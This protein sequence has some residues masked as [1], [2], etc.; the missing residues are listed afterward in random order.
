MA[1]VN[2]I[3]YSP[4]LLTYQDQSMYLYTSAQGCTLYEENSLTP[5]YQVHEP[6]LLA[7]GVMTAPDTVHLV[8]LKATGDLTYILI[9]SSGIPQIVS[10]G[11]LDIHSI[12]YSK[13]LLFPTNKSIHIFYAYSHQAIPNLWHI[14]HRYWNGKSWISVH[15]GEV[16]HSKEP[17]F[18]VSLD[19]NGNIHLL[20]MTFQGRQSIVFSNL[21][22]ITFNIWGGL[23]EALR[24]QGEAI[25]MNALMTPDNT[26]HLFWIIR[27]QS[28]QYELRWAQRIHAQDLASSWSLAPAPLRSFNAPWK[29]L[30]VM[31]KNGT[32]WIIADASET[33]LMAY[34]G[35]NWKPVTSSPANHRPLLWVRREE[36]GLYITPWLEDTPNKRSPIFHQ[37]LG[38]I[39]KPPVQPESPN[40]PAD[41]APVP[42]VPAYNPMIASVQTMPVISPAIITAPLTSNENHDPR[43][44]SIEPLLESVAHLQQENTNLTLALQEVQ[45]K[46]DQVLCMLNPPS[47]EESHPIEEKISEKLQPLQD[48]VSSLESENRTLT[49]ILENLLTRLDHTESSLKQ[50]EQKIESQL[51]ISQQQLEEQKNKGGLLSK[52]F[53]ST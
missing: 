50:F 43:P 25:D 19:S 15:L 7:Q 29:S 31:E 33:H 48:I 37:E 34:N 2:R 8:I 47:P 32:L 3:S 26:H 36:K 42:P 21:F 30:G 35:N 53:T 10:L 23:N 46:F 13:L 28:N 51:S 45:T 24:I 39:I 40:W 14:E 41:N 44:Q 18:H 6:I 9:T 38:M 11:K 1:K 12:R 16:V 27:T 17:M 4:I 22:N 52:W 5:L 20:T 49:S